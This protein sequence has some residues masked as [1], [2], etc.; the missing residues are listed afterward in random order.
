M[1]SRKVAR[2]GRI[3]SWRAN[4]RKSRRKLKR[5]TNNH[6]ARAFDV[7]NEFNT[8]SEE[9]WGFVC[10]FTN[11]MILEE[12]HDLHV[13]FPLF[14]YVVKFYKLVR[15]NFFNQLYE[16]RE[17]LMEWSISKHIA[18]D[19]C[20]KFHIF[21]FRDISDQLTTDSDIS[22]KGFLCILISLFGVFRIP[23]VKIR[24]RSLSWNFVRLWKRNR[25]FER[26]NF[27]F[28][29]KSALARSLGLRVGECV[30]WVRL[31]GPFRLP[32]ALFW[33]A[34]LSL[35]LFFIVCSS[36]FLS[37]SLCKVIGWEALAEE[38]QGTSSR[39]GDCSGKTYEK[40]RRTN[41]KFWEFDE[42]HLFIRTNC[43]RKC[44]E[45]Y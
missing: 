6:E 42:F 36:S 43:R 38:L 33:F 25:S 24:N 17:F 7:T 31:T 41:Q 32:F 3:R 40:F 5:R 29:Q 37:T 18:V 28:L 30:N 34:S 23:I 2:I 45:I 10:Q 27:L 44:S 8:T 12:F 22:W 1:Q 9:K 39:S 35:F 16:L 26:V 13:C 19:V 11:F 4:G 20:A 15:L 21:I 14:W